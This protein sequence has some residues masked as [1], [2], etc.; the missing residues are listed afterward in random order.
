MED[1]S[2]V[3]VERNFD[4]GDKLFPVL[5]NLC[6]HSR[7]EIANVSPSTFQQFALPIKLAKFLGNFLQGAE[8][9]ALDVALLF[10][11]QV[12]AHLNYLFQLTIEIISI[13][14]SKYGCAICF[15]IAFWNCTDSRAYPLT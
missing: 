5:P 10:V 15:V 7:D 2:G 11:E 14:S 4:V 6:F 1:F 8:I 9:E 12:V 13:Y 3:D